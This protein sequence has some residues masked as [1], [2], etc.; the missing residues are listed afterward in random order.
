MPAR[1]KVKQQFPLKKVC[2]NL[3]NNTY[4]PTLQFIII[5]RASK[6]NN[7]FLGTNSL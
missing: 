7:P 6:N 4:K 2:I 1:I 5:A 3:Q